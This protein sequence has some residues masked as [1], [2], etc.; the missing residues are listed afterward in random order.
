MHCIER[1]VGADMADQTGSSADNSP[2]NEALTG[3][4]PHLCPR[5]T[6]TGGARLGELLPDVSPYDLVEVSVTAAA[7]VAAAN[8]LH[9]GLKRR[10]GGCLR[11]GHGRA[12]A[13][14]AP[15]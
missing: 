4:Q 6:V 7:G 14:P 9:V 12:T 11:I 13:I 10:F 15:E 2:L 1:F 5:R 8:W 3:S